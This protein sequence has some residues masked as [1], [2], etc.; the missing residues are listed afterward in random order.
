MNGCGDNSGLFYA[1][2]SRGH[3][4]PSAGTPDDAGGVAHRRP[5]FSETRH[6]QG[7]RAAN[8]DDAGSRNFA[9]SHDSIASRL[10]RALLWWAVSVGVVVAAFAAV[11]R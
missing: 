10:I 2:L 6:A 5:E 11:L 8:D 7:S 1:T 4:D 3:V 9:D